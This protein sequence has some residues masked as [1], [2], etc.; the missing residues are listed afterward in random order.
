[1][2]GSGPV[3]GGRCGRGRGVLVHIGAGDIGAVGTPTVPGGG[4]G[5]AAG[6][7]DRRVAG[8]GIAAISRILGH[9]VSSPLFAVAWKHNGLRA[10]GWLSGMS[11]STR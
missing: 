2:A 7:V 5:H 6:G 4:L 9:F 11:G 8:I 1:M 3:V 10:P